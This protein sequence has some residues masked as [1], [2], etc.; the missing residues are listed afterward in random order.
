MLNLRYAPVAIV[1]L[2]CSVISE[3][4][5]LGQSKDF[6]PV[7]LSDGEILTIQSR[8]VSSEEF[9]LFLSESEY[10]EHRMHLHA[11][12]SSDLEHSKRVLQF[13]ESQAPA[14]AATFVS[15]VDAAYYASWLSYKE[16]KQYSLPTFSDYQKI[17]D[18]FR[19]RSLPGDE[20]RKSI[21][22]ELEKLGVFGL[23]D[24]TQELCDTWYHGGRPSRFLK[25]NGW[26]AKTLFEGCIPK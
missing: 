25:N 19:D 13:D 26:V 12:A 22:A 15:F 8:E 11:I 1:F 10:L 7:T 24:E 14:N 9:S 16:G 17:Y 6:I 3:L 20:S 21:T 2:T 5:A 23:F 18:T 4:P